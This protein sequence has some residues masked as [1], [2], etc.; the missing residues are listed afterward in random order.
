MS[1]QITEKTYDDVINNIKQDIN[2]TQLDIMMNANMNLV[3]LYYRIG[4]ELYDNSIWG[5]KFL[6]TLSFELRT[7][8]SN[9]KGFSVRNL[10]YMKAFYAEYRND[11][12]FVQLVAQLPWTH[13]MVLIEKVKNKNILKKIFAALEEKKSLK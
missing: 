1:K 7:T 3:S 12:E 8:Y 10:N 6:N 5:N 13:N 2:K 11:P 4:K 9:Q